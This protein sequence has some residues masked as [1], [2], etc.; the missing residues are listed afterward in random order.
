MPGPDDYHIVNLEDDA[1]P[2]N[3][4]SQDGVTLISR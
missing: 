1:L 3:R 2:L 4:S